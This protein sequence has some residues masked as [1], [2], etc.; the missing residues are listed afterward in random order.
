ME[1]RGRDGNLK[2]KTKIKYKTSEERYAGT[3]GE[4]FCARFEGDNLSGAGQNFMG[5]S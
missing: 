2:H 3:S 4:F 5:F 1:A